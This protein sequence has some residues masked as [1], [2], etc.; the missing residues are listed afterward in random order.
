MI[1][2]VVK[3]LTAFS[4][5]SSSSCRKLT[6]KGCIDHDPVGQ[7]YRNKTV[8]YSHLYSADMAELVHEHIRNLSIALKS[9]GPEF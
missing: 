6:I 9:K 4:L 8:D 1:F 2:S 5:L 7:F 3:N